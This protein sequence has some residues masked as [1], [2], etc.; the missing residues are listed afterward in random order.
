MKKILSALSATALLLAGVLFASCDG[1]VEGDT[2]FA[3]TTIG[4]PS[5]TAK[6]YPGVNILT[7]K[8]IKDAGSYVIYRTVGNGAI[9]E[10]GV[11][12][13]NAFYVD[14]AID[15]GTSYKY[16]V[17]AIPA[18]LTSHDASQTEVSLTTAKTATGTN[19]KGTWA[20]EGTVF[21]DLAQYESDYS[22][23]ATVLSEDTIAVKLVT[24]TGSSVRVMFP[25]KAYASYTI[26][27]S[28]VNGVLTN[29]SSVRE[30]STKIYGYNYNGSASVTLDA[31]Y[32]GVKQVT[33]VATP[34]NNTLYGKSQIASSTTV[35]V[36]AL[37]SI[38]SAVSGS[39]SAEWTNYSNPYA[40][41][42]VY[43]S[44]YVYDGE[45]FTTD[46]YTIFRAVYTSDGETSDTLTNSDGTALRIYD[47]ITNL[48]S[49]KKDT[50]VDP[51]GATVYYL[52]DTVNLSAD[53]DVAGVRYYVVLNHNGYLKTNTSRLV[54]PDSSDSSWNFTPSSGSSY[55]YTTSVS[56]KD[57]FIDKTGIAYVGVIANGYDALSGTYGTFNTLNEAKVAVESELPTELTQLESYDS[58]YYSTMFTSG[59]AT[60]DTSKYYAF[61]VL[62][63]RYTD[64]KWK[65]ET[66]QS[67]GVDG[68][69]DVATT[70]AKPYKVGGAYYWDV[71]V[72]N[73]DDHVTLGTTSLS[74]ETELGTENYEYVTLNYSAANQ[75]SNKV[76]Y[77]N[78]YRFVTDYSTSYWPYFSDNVTLLTT[79]TETTYTDSGIS[80]LSVDGN[81]IYYK[82]SA[83][84]YY[85]STES[86]MQK[87]SRLKTPVVYPASDG[88][89]LSWNR[90]SAADGY[91]IYR[92]KTQAELE[93]LSDGEY[94]Y[95]INSNYTTSTA[96]MTTQS[97]ASDYVYA[98]KAYAYE[99]YEYDYSNVSN[100]VTV[101]KA[102][103]AAPDVTVDLYSYGSSSNYSNPVYTW[104]LSWTSV[105]DYTDNYYILRYQNYSYDA[106]SEDE[107][108]A[109]FDAYNSS[110][111]YYTSVDNSDSYYS[112][113][114]ASSYDSYSY[115][116][117][118]A[119]RVYDTISETYV[120]G[121]SDV[122]EAENTIGSDLY[123]TGSS[124]SYTLSWTQMT[125]DSG[126]EVA[127]YVVYA[128]NNGYVSTLSATSS[129]ESLTDYVATLSPEA[130]LPAEGSESYSYTYTDTSYSY[131]YHF[132]IVVGLN[133]EGT[134]VGTT[135]IVRVYN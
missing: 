108:K 121:V 103:L 45:E 13:T 15:E 71:L 60:V 124:G 132:F 24:S 61:R 41:T 88:V 20:P 32:S 89:T 76:V 119:T 38:S 102:T 54:V 28:Q 110:S 95:D 39:V 100:F 120:Y 17:V 7:W 81:Y 58:T 122:I 107:I 40:T 113:A 67:E 56:I 99:N 27:L 70:I 51:N 63:T 129:T 97:Y 9:E 96:S 3:T 92:A 68:V 123:V 46:E 55:E 73:P 79:T 126:T 82:V 98:V 85:D 69:Y 64:Y 72:D 48:G 31:V 29:T 109:I 128:V 18:D 22:S 130:T 23:S 14:K 115:W 134:Q 111:A 127:T 10:T 116:Y 57:I 6:A 90:I 112:N 50:A 43:F 36:K 94:A 75:Y 30:T 53:N 74:V 101:E 25:T 125:D 84:G 118:V 21:S 26:Y 80:S 91:R 16:R 33:V 42:R 34:L 93:A 44:P 135:N 62:S 47:S 117:A 52:D 87:A 114:E 8:A 133:G 1:L 78:I 131:R 5:V 59:S 66:Q 104:K 77:Y 4:T 105:S 49:P 83:V 35:E 19:V 12:V 37:S 65:E 2:N 11:P 106:K 86:S